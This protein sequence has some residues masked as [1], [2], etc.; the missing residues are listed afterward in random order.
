MPDTP[1]IDSL[2]AQWVEAFNAHDLDRHMALYTPDAVLFG[3]VDVLHE[4]RDAIRGYFGNRPADVRVESYPAPVVR[5][6]GADVAITAG[7]VV[8]AAGAKPMPYRV[9]WALV[10]QNGNWMIAQHH[11]SPQRGN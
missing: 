10:R 2:I 11:G 7:H 8:F 3:S 4:G 6:L 1:T 5:N 9:T